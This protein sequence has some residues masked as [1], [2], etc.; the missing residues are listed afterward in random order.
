[1]PM[2]NQDQMPS[3]PPFWNDPDKRALIFQAIVLAAVFA[4]FAYI[5]SNT[6][7][8]LEKRGISTGV[9]AAR[10]STSAQSC[11]AWRSCSTSVTRWTSR[12]ATTGCAA[13]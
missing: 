10:S 3:R 9:S 7:H 8:N 2:D 5:F 1:M 13:T 4:F 11:A 6:L 12:A